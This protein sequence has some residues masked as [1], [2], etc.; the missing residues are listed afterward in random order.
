LE[1]V[2]ALFTA[3]ETIQLLSNH[4]ITHNLP[5]TADEPFDPVY[6]VA[7]KDETS[8]GHIFKAA[9]YNTTATIPMS[10]TFEGAAAPGTK[11][12]LTI[13]TGPA[14]PYGYNDPFLQNNVVKTNQSIVT[15][16]ATGAFTFVVGAQSVVVL[17]TN[18]ALVR[19]G[20]N[21]TAA[22]A[23]RAALAAE[24]HVG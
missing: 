8:G 6:W 19:P 7:G 10:V 1:S 20:C 11:G 5:T 4:I 22:K 3:N 23:R 2:L 9:V 17:D 24:A 16:D 18:P 21:A 13:L 14:N 15:A 12:Q